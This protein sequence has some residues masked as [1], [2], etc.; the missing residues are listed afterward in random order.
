MPTTR[1][2]IALDTFEHGQNLTGKEG[3]VAFLNEL[4]SDLRAEILA[5]ASAEAADTSQSASLGDLS[6]A[7]SDFQA[8]IAQASDAANSAL[9]SEVDALN[10]TVAAN[11]LL[12]L[13]EAA[14]AS[15]AAAAEAVDRANADA[16]VLDSANS[17]LSAE[18]D[19]LNT[20]VAANLLLALTEAA[21]ASSA[22]ASEAVE[23]AAADAAV[24]D[25]VGSLL[26]T[27]SSALN[28][29]I[30]VQTSITTLD[31]TPAIIST[32]TPSQLS[33]IRVFKKVIAHRVD[34][35]QSAAYTVKALARALPSFGTLT[36]AGIPA[37]LD[38][39]EIDGVTYTFKTT[40]TSTPF[41]VK[42]GGSAELSIDN[43]VAAIN[44]SGTD[45]VEYGAGTTAHPSV[46]A[47][48]PSASTMEAV[49]LVPGVAGNAL[50]TTDP[51]DGGG[52]LGWGGATLASGSDMD[53]ADIVYDSESEDN[54]AWDIT[55]AAVGAGYTLSVTGANGTPIVWLEEDSSL[56]IF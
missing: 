43:L 55:L 22:A 3:L 47:I 34:R 49:A 21:A 29:R 45:D 35:R 5:L 14:A 19:A 44:L 6:S 13:T 48:K 41:E 46:S 1:F 16:A 28:A 39:I 50:S 18:V 56:E 52:V 37:N 27:E 54:A 8:E 51:V 7:V 4:N 12:A 15:S 9:A 53:L 30:G 26:S 20:T 2:P 10:T 38:E 36:V 42:I 25:S 24:L 31:A 33:S 23:R 17:S 11:L 32:V 40:L